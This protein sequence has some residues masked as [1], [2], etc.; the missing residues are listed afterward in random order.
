MI[1]MIMFFVL[2]WAL[3]TA[4]ISLW[5]T[6]KKKEKWNIVKTVS[7]GAATAAITVVIL[8]LIVIIF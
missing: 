6:L 3:I 2:W 1:R 4:L 7:Y 8:S 5:R